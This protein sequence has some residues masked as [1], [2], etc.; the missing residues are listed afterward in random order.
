M[1]DSTLLILGGGLLASL[2]AALIFTPRRAGEDEQTREMRKLMT[3]LEG[4]RR[5][6]DAQQAREQRQRGALVRRPAMSVQAP[7]P[8]AEAP[9]PVPATETDVERN[10]RRSAESERK[11]A[12]AAEHAE[13]RAAEQR[14]KREE[15]EQAAARKAEVAVEREDRRQAEQEHKAALAA[16]Q[17]E[18]RA[19]EQRRR[20]EEKEQAAAREAELAA[21]RETLRQGHEHTAALAAE[22]HQPELKE[23][24]TAH[25]AELD[26]EHTEVP[27]AE[28]QI[29]SETE[30]RLLTASARRD[31]D[32]IARWREEEDRKVAAKAARARRRVS[33]RL[34]KRQEFAVGQTSEPDADERAAA[35]ESK[36]RADAEA[37]RRVEVERD[38]ALE[39]ER[40]ERLAAERRRE[41]EAQA[42]PPP[43]TAS[44]D[45]MA[46]L[47]AE[48]Q[49][50]ELKRQELRVAD[51]Q[52]TQQAPAA[53][54][55]GPDERPNRLS[56]LP[57]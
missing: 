21:A 42:T 16:E 1:T 51:E 28:E 46:A 25:E 7:A 50:L 33:E 15:K 38:K 12:I 14:R 4:Q 47:N 24:E 34:Y 22:H 52:E 45:H 29:R 53:A 23:I 32:E 13:R 19:A 11:A 17:A 3:A 9:A 40:A 56:D 41:Q 48:R 6:R 36:R 39:A 5:I 43:W 26:A 30:G 49:A 8:A 54:D 27:S 31:L 2:L 55:E 44:P 35:L 37:L 18:R 10:D 57:L 20:R